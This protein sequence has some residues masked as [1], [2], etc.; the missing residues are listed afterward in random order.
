MAITTMDGLVAALGAT[1]QEFNFYSPN[2]TNVA[3]GYINLARAGVTSFGQAAIPT[4]IG[5]GGHVPV[6]GAAGYPTIAAGGG[7]TTLYIARMDGFS[8]Q[9]GCLAI[10]DRVWAA[11]G[12]S[13]TLTSAQTI[14]GP[15][16][17]PSARAPNSGEGLEMYLESYTATGGSAATVTVSYTNPAGTA[18]RTSQVDSFLTSFPINRMQKIRLQ[19]G[20]TGVQSIQSLTLSAT[21]G[22]AGNFGV[23]LL[24]R[25]A[26]L[27][28]P[29]LSTA[30]TLDFASLGMPTVQS[31]SALQFVNIGSTTTSGLIIANF[32]I[33]SG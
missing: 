8:S 20:D 13:G 21:T 18:G 17:L 31:D 26:L 2:A 10:Y 4:V 1:N 27:S 3:G 19:D 7:G 22:T 30:Y 5:S 29:V 23:T 33:I 11:S 24:K 12:F 32:S 25:K 15:V 6:D 16:A 9:A 14:T 28:M